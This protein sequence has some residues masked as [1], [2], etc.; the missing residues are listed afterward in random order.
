M[1]TAESVLVIVLATIMAVTSFVG[2]KK[3]E[4]EI[5]QLKAKV[6]MCQKEKSK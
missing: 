6:E 2:N 1:S 4:K 3:Q 5:E